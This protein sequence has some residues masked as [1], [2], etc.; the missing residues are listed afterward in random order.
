MYPQP[1]LSRLA[2]HKAE[3][4]RRS[5]EQRHALATALAHAARPLAWLDRVQDFFSRCA[6][7]APLVATALGGLALRSFFTRHR[8]LGTLLRWAPLAYPLFRRS[9]ASPPPR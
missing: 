6:P 5:A 9:R 2:A 8:I 4:L 1:E 3:L 7:F